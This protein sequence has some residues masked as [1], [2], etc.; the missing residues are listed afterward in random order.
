MSNS[1]LSKEQ[2]ILGLGTMKKCSR[3]NFVRYKNG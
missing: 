3:F 1:C 2:I